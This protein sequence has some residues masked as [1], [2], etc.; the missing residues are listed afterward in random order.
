MPDEAEIT[1]AMVISGL[2]R[3]FKYASAIAEKGALARWHFGPVAQ[4]VQAALIAE[5]LDPAMYAF[6]GEDTLEGGGSVQILRLDELGGF[7][8]ACGV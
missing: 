2:Y 5:G 8:R 3:K 6:W 7:L 4:D 1:A